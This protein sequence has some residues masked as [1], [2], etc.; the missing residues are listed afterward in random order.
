MSTG[1]A[2]TSEGSLG[3]ILQQWNKLYFEPLGLQARLELSDS[4]NRKPKKKS[5][6]IRRPSLTYSSREEREWRNEDRKFLI[7]VAEIVSEQTSAHAHELAANLDRVELS[8]DS[9]EIP[10]LPADS[11]VM[12]SELPNNEDMAKEDL[13]DVICG[14]AE[15]PADTPVELSA[16][17]ADE[18]WRNDPA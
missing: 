1:L 7:V 3:G 17:G 2:D 15:L 9:R 10:E 14:M 16:D 13:A 18:K 4:A 8:G 11:K 12:L 5:R 6:V